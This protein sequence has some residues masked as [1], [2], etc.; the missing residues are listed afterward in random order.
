MIQSVI[1]SRHLVVGRSKHGRMVLSIYEYV[2]ETQR[3]EAVAIRTAVVCVH[4]ST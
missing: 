4:T 2:S 3:L 1:S